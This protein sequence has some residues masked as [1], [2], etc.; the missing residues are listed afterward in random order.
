[1]NSD[2]WSGRKVLVTG[3]TGFKGSWLCLWLHR[4]GA[5]VVGYALDPPTTPS[6]FVAADV[7]NSVESIR[8]DIR[9]VERLTDVIRRSAPDV[10]LHLAAQS[11]VRAS[12]ADPIETYS[13]NVLGTACVFQAVRNSGG[14]RTIVNITTDKVYHN[15][16]WVWGYRENDELGGHDPYSNSKACAELVTQAFRDSFF[17]AA[18]LGEHGV[19]IASARAGNVIG[20]GDWTADQL[21]PDV[22]RAFAA[23][24][25][26]MIRQPKSVRPWQHVLDCLSGYIL[27]A[28]RLS[29]SPP[30]VSGAWNFGPDIADARPVSW[31]VDVLVKAWGGDAAWRIDAGAHP[32]EAELLRLDASK[33]TKS[34]GWA[35]RL[36]LSEALAWT[37]D[38]YKS[39][40]AGRSARDLCADQIDRYTALQR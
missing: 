7:A 1:M 29:A 40:F 32:H 11:V 23:H 16:E 22:M 8:G 15:R 30:E 10:I 13:T 34:L 38:W 39:H 20:G 19:A 36:P 37:V 9:D 17:P 4:A 35:P 5:K 31:L 12:Y 3:H 21:I 2:F 25:P 28:E 6:L 26:V 27:L 33:A 14:A 24:R 18:K